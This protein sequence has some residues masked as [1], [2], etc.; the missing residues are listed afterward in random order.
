[1]PKK[2]LVARQGRSSP[3]PTRPTLPSAGDTGLVRVRAALKAV[4]T[5]QTWR[6]NGSSELALS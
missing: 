2:K 1:M 6:K 3:H 5:G 4:S